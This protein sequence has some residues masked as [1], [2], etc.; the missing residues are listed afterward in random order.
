MNSEHMYIE[1]IPPDL[2]GRGLSV[3]IVQARFNP[4]IG[5]GLVSAAIAELLKSGVEQKDILIVS[6]PGALEIPLMLQKLA[7]T[8]QFDALIAAGAVIRGETYHFEL[9]CN[10]SA[11]GISRV[12]LELDIPVINAVLTTENDA[13]A[14]ARVLEKGSEAGRAAVEMAN[15]ANVL[16]PMI[17]DDM[18]DLEPFDLDDL[19]DD[20]MD[21]D[22]DGPGGKPAGRPQ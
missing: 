4:A 15:L 8:G 9:V 6:V 20:E 21:D 14:E 3:G 1:R 22:F 17:P 13:Q 18:D 5:E 19:D 7:L 12:A 2:N 10:E 16:D 11:A